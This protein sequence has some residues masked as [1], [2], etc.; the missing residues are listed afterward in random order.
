M[1]TQ[2][3]SQIRTTYTFITWIWSWTWRTIWEQD[4]EI[5]QIR[6]ITPL[7]STLRQSPLNRGNTQNLLPPC[8]QTNTP[9]HHSTDNKFLLQPQVKFTKKS[10][11]PV[12]L[13]QKTARSVTQSPGRV[14][15]V[16]A[17]VK[18]ALE[19]TFSTFTATITLS[20]VTPPRRG[21][22]GFGGNIEWRQLLC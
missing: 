22:T 19:I 16:R 8:C 11:L 20:A 14:A 10:K 13:P 21:G 6:S 18:P 15:C 9:N 5:W 3:I 7:G 1:K 4:S 12:L 2:R 17:Q